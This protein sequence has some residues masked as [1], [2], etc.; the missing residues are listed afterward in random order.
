MRED[1]PQLA[2]RPDWQSL[3]LLNSY[4]LFIVIVL[5]AGFIATPGDIAFGQSAPQAF[6]F[7]TTAYAVLAVVFAVWLRR[8]Q[9]DHQTQCY[10]H[11]YT[12]VI[13]LGIAIHA[14]GGVA[15]GLGIL[16][17]VPVSGAGILL[18]T[19]Y[20]LVYAA[21]A[22]LLLLT[23]EA[24]RHMQLGAAATAYTQAALLG[25]ALFAAAILAGLLASRHAYSA[26]LARQ[27]S[28]DLRR[29]AELN[30]L[31]IQQMEAG[32]LVIDPNHRIQLAN[33]S[34]L[35]L[36]GQSDDI[37]GRPLASLSRRLDAAM[38]KHRESGQAPIRAITVGEAEQPRRLQVQF[39]DLG[40]QGTMIMLEDAA[41]IENQL[42]QLK[43]ASLGRLTAGIAHEIRNPLAAINHSAQLLVESDRNAGERR[44]LDIQLEHCQRINSIVESILQL[45][46][47]NPGDR[48]R[49]ELGDWL[50]DFVTEFRQQRDLEDTRLELQRPD[51]ALLVACHAGQLRQIL[52][53]LCNNCLQHGQTEDGS[54]IRITIRLARGQGPGP[55]IDVIDNGAPIPRDLLDDLFEPFYTTSHAGTGLGLYLARELCEANGAELYYVHREAGNCLRVTFRETAERDGEDE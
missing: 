44:L 2:T 22:T 46:R 23:S 36:L 1:A 37:T 15:S 52:T 33:A 13:L 29:L 9:P 49:F 25:I 54:P 50:G 20:S 48:D 16:L 27:R 47:R 28:V 7:A 5:L 19:R 32:I 40:E 4:R 34:G 51:D 12:D 26:A 6:Y 45:T 38:R 11:F 42:Q 14:S 24:V 18:Q 55:V 30:E 31:I 35:E 3:R 41:F 21:L 10:I 53:N 43:L 17:V 39:T 8:R